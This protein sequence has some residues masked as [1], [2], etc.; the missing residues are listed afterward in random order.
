MCVKSDDLNK[1]ILKDCLTIPFT[2]DLIYLIDLF[3]MSG[4]LTSLLGAELHRVAG[5]SLETAVGHH[6]EHLVSGEGHQVGENACRL[7]HGGV[8]TLGLLLLADYQARNIT[9]V[10]PV[11]HLETRK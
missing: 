11:V 7:C 10:T 1:I 9:V 3:W 4:I 8:E 2:N 6:H 5:W